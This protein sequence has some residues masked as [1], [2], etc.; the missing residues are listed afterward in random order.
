MKDVE[1]SNGPIPE[2]AFVIPS[3][4]IVPVLNGIHSSPFSGHMGVKRTLLR[5]RTRFF[6]PKM[7]IH[8]KDFVNSC[9]KCAERK[10]G[11]HSNKAPPQ[12]IEVNEPFVFWAMDYMGP[13][14]ETAHGNKHLLVIMDHF[15][16]W[17]EAFPT[18][19]QRASTV[20]ELLVSRVFSRFG[21]QRLF[22]LIKGETLKAI[23]CMKFVGS[24]G[25]ISLAPLHT[26]LSV[27]AK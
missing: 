25:Y 11:P 27:M 22:I 6:W 9:A 19:D 8:I 10:H 15:T 21:P 13:L 17:C 1:S 16:K 26:I 5:A 4:L 2:Y 24:W 3:K 12:T 18:K 14:P 7:A 20:A 23:L